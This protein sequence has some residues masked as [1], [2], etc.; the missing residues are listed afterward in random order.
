MST[1]V[2]G[3]VSLYKFTDRDRPSFLWRDNPPFVLYEVTTKETKL[4]HFYRFF[5]QPK[6]L[7]AASMYGLKPIVSEK[8]EI[9]PKQKFNFLVSNT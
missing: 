7:L 2:Y 8:K 6:E 1:L 3:S 5:R 4:G 9:N